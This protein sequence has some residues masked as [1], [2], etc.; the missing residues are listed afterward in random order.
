VLV[1]GV[2]GLDDEMAVSVQWDCEGAC[3]LLWGGLG[4]GSF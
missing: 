3:V 2:R 4:R 1:N